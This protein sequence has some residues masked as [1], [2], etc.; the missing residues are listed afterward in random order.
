MSRAVDFM[1]DSNGDE[2][3]VAWPN[4]SMVKLIDIPPRANNRR[5][6]LRVTLSETKQK[7]NTMRVVFQTDLKVD[8]DSTDD[9][10]RKAFIDLVT[11]KAREAFGVAGVL[12][13]GTPVVQVAVIDRN[14]REDIPLFEEAAR[15]RDEDD[16]D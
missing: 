4:N 2:H 3:A 11:L 14:G 7:D 15:D 9:K 13:R 16:A 1:I 5:L 6:T 8:L 12:A 10:L